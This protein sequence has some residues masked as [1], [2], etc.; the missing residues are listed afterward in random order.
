[1]LLVRLLLLPGRL[2]LGLLRVRLLL[3]LGLLRVRLL[4]LLGL[5]LLLPGRL[6]GLRPWGLLLL[7]GRLRLGLLLL[8]LLLP[9][10]L[11]LDLLRLLLGC[12]LSLLRLLRPLGCCLRLL[13][14]LGCCLAG[15]L[16]ARLFLVRWFLWG[17]IRMPV[18][19]LLVHRIHNLQDS[20]IKMPESMCCEAL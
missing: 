5:M 15:S 8:L 18:R 7:P 19:A 20:S 9:G 12:C 14:L 13:C 10:R 16:T 17:N 1:L 4:L 2:L 11:L 3:L 6:R